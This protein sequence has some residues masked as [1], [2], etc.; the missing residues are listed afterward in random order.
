MQLQASRTL[1]KWHKGWARC[2]HAS[3]KPFHARP[4]VLQQCACLMAV[5][6]TREMSTACLAAVLC[7]NGVSIC[8]LCEAGHSSA[9]RHTETWLL[10]QHTQHRALCCLLAI[11]SLVGGCCVRHVHRNFTASSTLHIAHAPH[12]NPTHR[13]APARAASGCVRPAQPR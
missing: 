6:K 8:M 7:M 12:H 10:L 2:G 13:R 4:T 5:P 11:L 9:C 3:S 1:P